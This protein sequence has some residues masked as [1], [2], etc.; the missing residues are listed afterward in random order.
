MHTYIHTHIHTHIYSTVRMYV[1]RF[2]CFSEYYKVHTDTVVHILHGYQ[3]WL[4]WC[5][6]DKDLEIVCSDHKYSTY[7]LARVTTKQDDMKQ[8]L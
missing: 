3:Y 2:N 7:I 6:Q 1:F 4:T 5:T 8:I